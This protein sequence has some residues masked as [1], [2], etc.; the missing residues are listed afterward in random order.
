MLW[1]YIMRLAA[2]YFQR[3]MMGKVEDR[4]RKMA[5]M[6]TR[7]EEKR[8]ARKN[9]RKREGT[10]RDT[11]RAAWRQS[12]QREPIIPKDYAEDVEFVEVKTFSQT[13]IVTETEPEDGG[14]QIR[15]EL[16]VEDVEFV[17]IREKGNPENEKQEQ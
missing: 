10:E 11:D 14:G 2:P 4:F 16:Q 1:P 8:A 12:G 3:W 5:G 9:R 15:Y 17:E 6:P 7:K 13:E